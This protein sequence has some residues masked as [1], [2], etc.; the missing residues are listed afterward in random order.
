MSNKTTKCSVCKRSFIHGRFLQH[1]KYRPNCKKAHML[2]LQDLS[3]SSASIHATPTANK[4][5]KTT[6]TT[7]SPRDPTSSSNTPNV[8]RGLQFPDNS[9]QF[10]TPPPAGRAESEDETPDFVPVD[11]DSPNIPPIPAPQNDNIPA[12][13]A[14]LV[15]EKEGS[16]KSAPNL[17][18][19]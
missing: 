14:N 7:G 2:K 15:P 16:S 10:R 8:R 3:P 4:R 17:T 9:E 5:A 11:D 1:L 12:E 6:T 18:I 13:P 19:M